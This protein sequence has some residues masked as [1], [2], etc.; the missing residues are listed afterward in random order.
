M[1]AYIDIC[2]YLPACWQHVDKDK[3]LHMYACIH[4]HMY[5]KSPASMLTKTK[6]CFALLTCMYGH[7]HTHMHVPASIATSALRP[8][9]DLITP[10]HEECPTRTSSTCN[11]AMRKSMLIVK[12]T[13]R[14]I[15]KY[16]KKMKNIQHLQPY[17]DNNYADSEVNPQEH[18]KIYLILIE[19]CIPIPC[20]ETNPHG[21]VRQI[22]TDS[23]DKSSR[24][25]ETNPHGF[26]RQILTDLPHGMV[27]R[28]VHYHLYKR[29]YTCM[30]ALIYIYIYIY[31]YDDR[32]PR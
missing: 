1:H 17:H 18:M 22:L 13:H 27:L 19:K 21:F 31:I 26:V 25:R 9:T 7:T 3:S 11:H 12:Y 23:W 2:K 20:R 4:R 14:N 6:V 29:L 8:P 28:F 15:W 32:E 16:T 10:T 30:Q 24:I 5:D